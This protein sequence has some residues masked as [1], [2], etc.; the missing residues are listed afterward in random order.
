LVCVNSVLPANQD[1]RSPA[2][3]AS[4]GRACAPTGLRPTFQPSRGRAACSLSTSGRNM[5]T[6]EGGKRAFPLG[7]GTARLQGRAATAVCA[8]TRRRTSSLTLRPRVMSKLFRRR[9]MAWSH[10]LLV[11]AARAGSRQR[12]PR[13]WGCRGRAERR[14]QRGVLRGRPRVR[15]LEGFCQVPRKVEDHRMGRG[16]SVHFRGPRAR[17][18]AASRSSGSHRRRRGDV[19]GR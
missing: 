3:P 5:S 15:H 4:P 11:V 12:A 14:H 6:L 7:L 19:P 13:C 8:Q 16:E 9:S 18:V 2:H 1:S 10:P 17:R